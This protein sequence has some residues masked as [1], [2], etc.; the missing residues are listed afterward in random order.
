MNSD[1]EETSELTE[2]DIPEISSGSNI[3]TPTSNI[4][5]PYKDLPLTKLHQTFYEH[6]SKDPAD[7]S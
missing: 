5:D 1:S 4:G 2:S 3:R 6:S 7:A